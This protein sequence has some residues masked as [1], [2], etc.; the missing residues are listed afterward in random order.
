MNMAPKPRALWKRLLIV[1]GLS[2][3]LAWK[4][5]RL[6]TIIFPSSLRSVIRNW[7]IPMFAVVIRSLVTRAFIDQTCSYRQPASYRPRVEVDPQYR[8]SER[9]IRSFHERGFVGPFDAFSREAMQE[10]R[11]ELL[12][13]K[14]TNSRTYQFATPRDRHFEMPRLMEFLRSPPIV[15]RAAQLLGPD[16]LCWR[17]QIFYKTAGADK[18]QWH[19]ASTFMVE[20]YLDPAIFPRH[21]DELFQLTVWVAVDDATLENGCLE[22][23][24]G[25]HDRIRTINFGGAK[26]EGF[27]QANFDLEFDHDPTRVSKLEV[28]AGQFILFTERCIHGSSANRSQRDR[29]AFNFRVIPTDVAVYPNKD[30]YRSV[31]NGGKYEL[32]NWGVVQLRGQDTHGLSRTLDVDRLLPRR[33]RA[34]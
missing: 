9:E 25:S 29:L 22:F 21:R 4:L 27:Y 14:D 19:Q 2:F 30:R 17:S 5:L 23:V 28:K 33:N 13:V 6:P 11:H 24:R 31:Y 20:D 8:M 1:I 12:A 3:L 16:L 32:E 26:A 15:E 10:F 18:I 34:A 7:T